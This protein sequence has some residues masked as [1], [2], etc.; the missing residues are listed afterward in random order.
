M[1]DQVIIKPDPETA[2]SPLLDDDLEDAADLEFYDSSI[3][4][5]P[6]GTMYLARIPH[7]LWQAWDKLDDDAEIQI[8][9]IRQ[10]NEIDKEGKPVVRWPNKVL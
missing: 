10:W 6:M 8:G 2:G 7:S 4:G 5:D 3:P 9:T 1:A